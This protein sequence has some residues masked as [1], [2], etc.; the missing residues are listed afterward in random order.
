MCRADLESNPVFLAQWVE[1]EVSTLSIWISIPSWKSRVVGR[2][3][4]GV[5]RAGSALGK[6][7]VGALLCGGK[8]PTRFT[9]YLVLLAS[10]EV[11]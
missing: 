10:C 3:K 11:T 8:K 4:A 2:S 9:G 5:C 7:V 1:L 6:A